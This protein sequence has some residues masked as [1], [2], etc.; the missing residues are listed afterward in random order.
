MVPH[1]VNCFFFSAKFRCVQN[2]RTLNLGC[3][4]ETKTHTVY[5]KVNTCHIFFNVSSYP[6][7]A[8][9]TCVPSKLNASFCTHGH[10]LTS[11]KQNMWYTLRT[12]YPNQPFTSKIITLRKTCFITT[13]NYISK[14]CQKEKHSCHTI[15]G[16]KI[17]GCWKEVGSH[18]ELRGTL[19]C[20][21][22]VSLL[23]MTWLSQRK[24]QKLQSKWKSINLVIWP[25]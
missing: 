20:A 4:D 7:K 9:W 11:Q 24:R 14:S 6:W 1:P 25:F 10:P 12:Q 13:P 23:K 17:R 18:A 5:R 21:W 8:S 2:Q 19:V 22:R 3:G 15:R 16:D